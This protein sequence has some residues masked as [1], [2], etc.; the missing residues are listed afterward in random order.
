MTNLEN[1]FIRACKSLKPET[2]LNSI[3]SRFYLRDSDKEKN[4]YF[5]IGLL[6]EIID[7][8]FDFEL[9]KILNE[10]N[11]K[12]ICYKFEYKDAML[13]TLINVIR[14]KDKEKLPDGYRIPAVFR[15]KDK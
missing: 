9:F 11:D 4:K 5:L 1:L 14:F 13:R 2:R 3:V 15:N 12:M 8:Y 10:V 6:S 7:N